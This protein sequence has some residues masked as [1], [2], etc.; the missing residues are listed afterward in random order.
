MINDKQLVFIGIIH[1]GLKR[2]EDCPRL[3]NENAPEATVE[4]FS[5]FDEAV[6]NILPGDEII[7]FTWLHKADR[8]ILKTRPRNDHTLP[9]TGVFS[10]RSPD[11]PNPIGIHFVRV[12]AILD[13]SSIKVS[14]LEVLDQTPVIDIKPDL[15]TR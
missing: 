14:G 8:M 11:R 6:K 9:L 7:L 4:I 15:R 3:E 1:S 12:I 2:L 13:D 5:E 10:T